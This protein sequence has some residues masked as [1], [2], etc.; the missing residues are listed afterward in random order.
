MDLISRMDFGSWFQSF[1]A[2]AWKA[3]S[4]RVGSVF[5]CRGLRTD[6]EDEWRLYLLLL[7]QE[8]K[9]DRLGGA[10]PWTASKF[11]KWQ[12]MYIFFLILYILILY[13]VKFYLMANK[14]LYCYTRFLSLSLSLSPLSD[15]TSATIALHFNRWSAKWSRS[16][17]VVGFL[18]LCFRLS[19]NQGDSLLSTVSFAV[20]TT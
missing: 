18:M 20:D 2:A 13:S 19:M 6:A 10:I 16:V 14:L 9:L 5:R 12:L 15:Q 7:D 3:L 4:P 8:T 17:V 11:M 1:G